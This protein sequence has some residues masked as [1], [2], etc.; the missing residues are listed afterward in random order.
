MELVSCRQRQWY[1]VDVRVEAYA[2]IDEAGRKI[3]TKGTTR[4]WVVDAESFSVEFVLNSLSVEFSWGKNQHPAIW[5]F[6]KSVGEDVRLLENSQ[7]PELFAMYEQESHFQLIISILDPGKSIPFALNA[8]EP[9]CVV[10]PENHGVD[11]G[12]VAG[13]AGVDVGG[14]GKG[15]GGGG[16]GVGVG[17][18][19]NGGGVAVDVGGV[20]GGGVNEGGVNACGDRPAPTVGGSDQPAT[21][22]ADVRE[23]DLFDNEEERRPANLDAATSSSAPNNNNKKKTPKKKRTPQKR[24]NLVSC[25]APPPRIATRLADLLGVSQPSNNA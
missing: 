18:A 16:G 15:G 2:T 7:I 24:R 11:A 4:Q 9:I 21:A 20:K 5:F 13:M 10:S 8:L 17:V 3:Y 1:Y 25:S 22:E 23:P 14:A 12:G 6:H 19:S